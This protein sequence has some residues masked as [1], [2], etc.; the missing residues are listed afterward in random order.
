MSGMISNLAI[1]LGAMQLSKRINWEDTSVLNNIRLMYIASNV[2]LLGIFFYIYTQ[3]QKKN[4]NICRWRHETHIN[5]SDGVKVRRLSTT[6]FA[7]ATPSHYD[8]SSRLRYDAV[9]ECSQIRL[10]GNCHDGGHAFVL[11]IHSASSR[12]IYHARQE[13][14]R[15]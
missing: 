15:E 9:E 6:I 13:C 11:W 4:G 3:I 1:I 7:R 5:R 2:I 14:L 12:P 10:H 8:D